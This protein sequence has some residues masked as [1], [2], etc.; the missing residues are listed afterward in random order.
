[1]ALF[2]NK[3]EAPTAKRREDARKKGQIAKSRE[4]T[5]VVALVVGLSAVRHLGPMIWGAW[6]DDLLSALTDALNGDRELALQYAG[7]HAVESLALTVGPMLGL[8]MLSGLVSNL[9]QTGFMLV[10]DPLKIDSSACS[11]LARWWSWP[12]R[13][14]KSAWWAMSCTAG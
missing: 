12:S 11:P 4:L 2:D 13:R 6:R 8:M 10:S 9:A 14:P 1:M 5:S 3:T 7:I